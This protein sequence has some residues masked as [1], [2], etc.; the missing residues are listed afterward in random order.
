MWT[1]EAACNFLG[2]VKIEQERTVCQSGEEHK[3][4]RVVK[5]VEGARQLE[6]GGLDYSTGELNHTL[7]KFQQCQLYKKPNSNI[8]YW[9]LFG[10]LRQIPNYGGSF[11]FKSGANFHQISQAQYD[12]A[13]K[14]QQ[15]KPGAT[16]V[17]YHGSFFFNDYKMNEIESDAAFDKCQFDMSKMRTITEADFVKKQI[18]DIITV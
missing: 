10:K 16:L 12:A 2:G 18:G 6:G 7:Y 8:E 15:V 13:P 5:C 1:D 17:K 4:K 3:W 14:G 9:F 11:L